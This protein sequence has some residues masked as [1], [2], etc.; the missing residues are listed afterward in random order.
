[1]KGSILTAMTVG[2]GVPLTDHTGK[3]IGRVKA[4]TCDNEGISVTME[5]EDSDAIAALCPRLDVSL[6]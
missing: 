2:D 6:E 5:V 3:Q 4:V 1:M